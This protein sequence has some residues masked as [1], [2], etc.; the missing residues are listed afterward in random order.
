M[1][2]PEVVNSCR[3]YRVRVLV[4]APSNSALDEIVLRV[5]NTGTSFFFLNFQNENLCDFIPVE[6]Q[7]YYCQIHVLYWHTYSMKSF[8]PWYASRHVLVFVWHGNWVLEQDIFNMCYE[9][10]CPFF[11]SFFIFVLVRY[12]YAQWV[13]TFQS[14]TYSYWRSKC[15]LSYT[16]S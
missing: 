4:C 11:L 9:L 6:C 1:Q 7:N 5:L 16:M 3:K 14:S 15:H 8:N 10:G 13:L 2:K 12:A